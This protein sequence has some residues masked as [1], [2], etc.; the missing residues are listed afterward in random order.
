MRDI[1][2]LIKVRRFIGGAFKSSILTALS[3][4]GFALMLTAAQVAFA[5]PSPP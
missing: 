2:P 5:A 3:V 1:D 4:T